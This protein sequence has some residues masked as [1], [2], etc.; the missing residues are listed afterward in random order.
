MTNYKKLGKQDLYVEDAI[1]YWRRIALGVAPLIFGI[2]AVGLGTVRMR[3]VKSNAVLVCVGIV[4]V[5]WIINMVGSSA[6]EKHWV[7]PFVA[8]QFSNFLALPLALWTFRR[9]AW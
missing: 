5:Y 6:A 7:S 9:S 8:I 1:E 2:L 3:S 4:M